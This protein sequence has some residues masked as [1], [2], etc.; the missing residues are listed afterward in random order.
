M[1]DVIFLFTEGGGGCKEKDRRR[2]RE[3][4][5]GD[6]SF[7]CIRDDNGVQDVNL[8]RTNYV[9]VLWLLPMRGWIEGLVK[10]E[11]GGGEKERDA[12]M[13]NTQRPPQF[14]DRR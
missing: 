9:G 2:K 1:K 14:G 7:L 10:V 4:G 5:G 8:F 11:K 12:C 13:H 3:R 6:V